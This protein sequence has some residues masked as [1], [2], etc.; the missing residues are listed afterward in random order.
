MLLALLKHFDAKS[1]SFA[2]CAERVF[3]GRGGIVFRA[4]VKFRGSA[5]RFPAPV[6]D[7]GADEMRKVGVVLVDDRGPFADASVGYELLG[8][9]LVEGT[10]QIPLVVL[11]V[12]DDVQLLQ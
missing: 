5:G 12:P 4:E 2:F 11:Q 3:I 8:V 10:G 1:Q 6:F 9:A 7:G